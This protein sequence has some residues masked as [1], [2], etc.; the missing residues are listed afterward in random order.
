L[1]SAPSTN[2]TI[3]AALQLIRWPQW[4]K[5]SFVFAVP[6]F[7]KELSD[8]PQ[9]LA[10]CLA[11]ASFCLVSSSVYILNDTVDLSRDR[12]HPEKRNRPLAS[13]ALTVSFALSLMLVLFVCALALAYY[14]AGFRLLLILVVYALANVLYSYVL[15]HVVILD[16][17]FI[18]V[19]FVLRIMAGAVAVSAPPSA[20]LILCTI[21]VSLFLGFAKRR[22]EVV[23]LGDD[24]HTHRE[25]LAH[26]SVGFLDQMISVVTSSTLVCYI[27]YTVDE[28][29]VA[30]FGNQGF[31]ATVPFV[32]YGIFRYLYLTYHRDE[33]GSPTRAVLTDPMFLIN[34]LLWGIACIVILYWGNDIAALLER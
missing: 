5:N 19:G 23:S 13:G 15:K 34:N 11:F 16:V 29:T 18:A 30:Y 26:Y 33:G 4:I 6:L 22:A 27:L 28:T 24:A 20:W 3:G 2:G 14:A 7:A 12:M 25:V 32:M 17:G 1:G 9:L 31:V 10:T 21:N 8:P